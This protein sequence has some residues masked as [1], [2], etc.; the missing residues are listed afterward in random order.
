[1]NREPLS[2]IT[3]EH[4]EAYKRDG[5]VLVKR[6][7]DQDWISLLLDG[8]EQIGMQMRDAPHEL[9]RLPGRHLDDPDLAAEIAAIHSEDAAQRKLYTEQAPGFVRCKY[10]RWWSSAF[11]Q[12]AMDSPAGAVV[13]QVIGA[14]EI[15]FFVDA[16]FVKAPG[17]ATKTYWHP[18]HTAWPT[19]SEQ[20]PTMWMP[21]LPVDRTLSSLEYLAGS[22]LDTRMP[23][24]NTFNA[25]RIGRPADRETFVDYEAKRGEAGLRFLSYDMVPGD[26]IIMHPRTYHG[27]GANLHP[28]QPRIALSTRW[29]GDEVTWDPRPECINIPGMP[30]THMRPG[31]K[32]TDE[33]VFPLV[34]RRN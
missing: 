15:R 20:V 14:A 8:W 29:F 25:K 3:A 27:G 16:M 12:F 13:G 18:D 26:V 22:H 34:W 4:A 11:R 30:R 32:P 21:L 1:M 5:V 31:E 10:M 24:P 23:W 7:F 6:V 28:T 19:L 17:L 9:Y 2:P 33:S